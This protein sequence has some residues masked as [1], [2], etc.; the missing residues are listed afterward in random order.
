VVERVDEFRAEH[1]R[2]A[3]LKQRVR[4]APS[5]LSPQ[6]CQILVARPTR[7]IQKLA[8][9]ADQFGVGKD[10]RATLLAPHADAALDAG[11]H[12]SWNVPG[13]TARP[14]APHHTAFCW[15]AKPCGSWLRPPERQSAAVLQAR[16]LLAQQL[17][18][19]AS[20]PARKRSRQ[21]LSVA[22]V[23]RCLREVDSQIGPSKQ[24]QARNSELHVRIHS[25]NP[26]HPP[27]MNTTSTQ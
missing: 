3:C 1:S 21:S 16:D 24:L 9:D 5:S 7:P 8:N 27:D 23:T 19:M 14:R 10:P 6:E 17:F 20:P 12:R 25:S 2:K 11:R 26:H 18:S 13:P 4:F 22:T 15:K